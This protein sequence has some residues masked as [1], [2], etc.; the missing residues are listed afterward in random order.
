MSR[1]FTAADPADAAWAVYFLS[2]H[3]PKRLVPVRRLA[4]W[5]MEESV[6]PDW[7]FEESYHAV[8]DLAETIALLLPD[9][10]ESSSDSHFMSWVEQRLL[11][12]G[13]ACEE[14]Q[15][16]N[17][18]RCVAITRGHRAIRLEQADHRKFSRRSVAVASR[19]GAVQ[20]ERCSRMDDIASHGG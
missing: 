13:R 5:A 14:D 9:G 8:G 6:V 10:A 2:G 18:A 3:R 17:R 7:L 12:I 19:S 15:Q 11:P 20:C 1:Y 4:A 16:A